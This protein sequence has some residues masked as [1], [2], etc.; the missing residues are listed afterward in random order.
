MATAKAPCLER[1]TC[2]ELKTLVDAISPKSAATAAAAAA[3]AT[4]AAAAAAVAVAARSSH[5]VCSS[6]FMHAI[7]A[8]FL[9]GESVCA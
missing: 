9:N 7:C 6:D 3:A 4:A 2:E 8:A 1:I 5:Q